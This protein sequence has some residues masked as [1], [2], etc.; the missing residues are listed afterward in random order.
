MIARQYWVISLR[1]VLHRVLINCTVCVRLDAKA[2]HPFM[3]D[4][5]R[6]RIQPRRPFDQVG[7]DYAGPLQLKESRLRK[8]RIFKI[9]I[10]VFI[11]FTT[12][13]VHLK[14]VTELSTDAFLVGMGNS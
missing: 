10:A 1:L 8:S 5:P 6:A 12:K 4:L 13:A 3:A 11:C 2:T 9:Y 14:V 7:V